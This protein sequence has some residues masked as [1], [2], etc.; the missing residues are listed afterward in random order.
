MSLDQDILVGLKDLTAE[1]VKLNKCRYSV[2]EDSLVVTTEALGAP[3]SID[4]YMAT[5]AQ[6]RR[7][8]DPYPGGEL[9]K[10]TNQ[11]EELERLRYQ[12]AQLA[13][14]DYWYEDPIP[15]GFP[16]VWNDIIDVKP[17][18]QTGKI[19]V[20]LPNASMTVKLKLWGQFYRAPANADFLKSHSHN[21]WAW[22]LWK[23]T[24]EIDTHEYSEGAWH[25]NWIQGTS[26]GSGLTT[27]NAP[28]TVQIWIDGTDRTAALGGP[29]GDGTTE[30]A[31]GELDLSSYLT[32]AGEHYIEIKETG[33]VGGRIQYEIQ[34]S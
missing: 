34:A 21:L 12:I 27:T 6:S 28:K 19:Y 11:A 9:S 13:G 1:L 32:T 5:V 18:D 17:S 26:A 31:T 16:M 3:E 10:A 30:F 33:A 15:A 24:R 22:R 2:G 14:T 8:T 29:W 4:D 23:S 25:G 20:T 7:Q